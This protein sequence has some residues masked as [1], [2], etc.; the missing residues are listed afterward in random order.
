VALV[1]SARASILRKIAALVFPISVLVQFYPEV[2]DSRSFAP[3]WITPMEEPSDKLMEEIREFLKNPPEPKT[4]VLLTSKDAA[5][6]LNL[7]ESTLK[8]WRAQGR[9]P[10]FS[11]LPAVRYR[12]VDLEKFIRERTVSNSPESPK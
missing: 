10:L 12:L 9:G 4:E 11:K 3:F 7:S 6:Y 8:K 5:E 1:G 2:T